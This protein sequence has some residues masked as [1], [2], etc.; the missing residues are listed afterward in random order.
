MN[1]TSLATLLLA[2]VE[3]PAALSLTGLLLTAATIGTGVWLM[4]Q[5][6]AKKQPEL[7]RSNRKNDSLTRQYEEVNVW[8]QVN[9]NRRIGGIAA[10]FTCFL[11]INIT[12]YTQVLETYSEPV[13]MPSEITLE[14]PVTPPTPPA[15]ALPPPPI[16]KHV[17]VDTEVDENPEIEPEPDDTPQYDPNNNTGVSDPNSQV[18]PETKPVIEPPKRIDDTPEIIDIAEQM[19]R[20][21]GCE[22]MA[23]DDAAKKQCADQRLMNLLFS[24]L[25]YPQQAREMGIEGTVVV[26]FIV[27]KAGNVSNIELRKKIGG[28]CD[29]EA[30][31]VVRKMAAAPEKWIP[32]R[33]GGRAV[34]VRFNLPIKFKLK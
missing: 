20:F 21:Y 22:D 30:L 31:R 33:Q 14:P 16:D 1:T 23:G 10:L 2:G 32:G 12:H 5:L 34:N 24:E 3:I 26:S 15:P 29:E 8:S 4:R 18:V 11:V 27:D 19:P 7:Q 28:G 25:K 13:E 6:M 17:V 9:R